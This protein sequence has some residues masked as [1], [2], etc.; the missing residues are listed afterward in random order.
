M[1]LWVARVLLA[2][3]FGVAGTAKLADRAGVRR[4]ILEFGLPVRIA[5]PL[6]WVLVSC[7][8]GVTL[9]LLFEPVATGGAFGALVL[10]LGFSVAIAVN[11]ARGR[12]P[13]CHCFGRL[14]S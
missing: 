13:D 2:V 3:V 14:L 4:A 6:G 8:L 7:E 10:P 9:A 11:L 12:T 1:A 5:A